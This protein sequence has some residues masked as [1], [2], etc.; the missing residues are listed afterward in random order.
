MLEESEGGVTK[1]VET[2]YSRKLWRT[3]QWRCPFPCRHWK[4]ASSERFHEEL[5]APRG[6]KR[7][8]E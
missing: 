7:A 1:A 4:F 8:G 5:Y 3:L 2:A 6:G